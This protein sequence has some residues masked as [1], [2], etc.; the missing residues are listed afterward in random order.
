MTDT[1]RQTSNTVRADNR[2]LPFKKEEMFV[3]LRALLLIETARIR[4]LRNPAAAKAFIGFD[5][6]EPARHFQQEEFLEQDGNTSSPDF[7]STTSHMSDSVRVSNHKAQYDQSDLSQ[8]NANGFD[9]FRVFDMAY[10][11][12]FQTGNWMLVEAC[13][14]DVIR[15]LSYGFPQRDVAGNLSPYYDERSRCRHILEMALARARVEYQDEYDGDIGSTIREL[16]LL[17][18]MSEAAVRNSLSAEGIKTEGKPARVDSQT[19]LVWLAARRGYIPGRH[20]RE[21]SETTEQRTDRMFNGVALGNAFAHALIEAN[22]AELDLDTSR[23]FYDPDGSVPEDIANASG[24]EIGFV[25]GLIDGKPELDIAK[26]CRLAKVL[27]LDAPK[28]A[29][30]VAAS[31]AKTTMETTMLQD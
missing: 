10:D 2:K 20:H 11:Y 5:I 13:T 8:I 4:L 12:A 15:S 29:A 25:Q 24:V 14:V 28:F 7:P 9:A 17:A 30:Y 3:E 6:K 27:K 31:A 1:L 22:F 26:L 23:G 19:A 21:T 18:N 16:S